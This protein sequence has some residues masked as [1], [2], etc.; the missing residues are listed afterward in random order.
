MLYSTNNL[1]RKNASL[2]TLEFQIHDQPPCAGQAGFYYVA[3]RID[4]E[5]LC[6]GE[7][8][9]RLSNA[10][11]DIVRVVDIFDEIVDYP[12]EISV[13]ALTRLCLGRHPDANYPGPRAEAVANI[14]VGAAGAMP[15]VPKIENGLMIQ[16]PS[17]CRDIGDNVV[18]L[19]LPVRGSGQINPM[20]R[21]AFGISPA[22]AVEG[23]N[24][25]YCALD[26]G[27]DYFVR[28]T[29]DGQKSVLPHLLSVCGAIAEL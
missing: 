9:P 14:F 20:Q 7:T 10:A 2:P 25:E 22:M 28:V 15:F 27:I 1:K 26:G 23:R 4:N 16:V 11:L 29:P 17:V 21:Y 6:L 3:D 13:I 18:P 12:E 24:G 5:L 19:V 8:L